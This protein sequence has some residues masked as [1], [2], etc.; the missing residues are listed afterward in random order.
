MILGQNFH[1][2]FFGPK[3]IIWDSKVKLE[4]AREL[5][6]NIAKG[7]HENQQQIYSL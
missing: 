1:N 5:D 7:S 2:V 3:W 4:N 6:Y